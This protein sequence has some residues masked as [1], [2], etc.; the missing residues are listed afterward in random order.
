MSR[1]NA[2]RF[3]TATLLVSGLASCQK[4]LNENDGSQ[5][6]APTE[7]N[8]S[9]IQSSNLV[10][11]APSYLRN[12]TF[13]IY[14]EDP[15][16][17]GKLIAKAKLDESAKFA[18]NYIFPA[19][20]KSV[21]IR[22]TYVG[23]PDGITIPLE[24][25]QGFYDYSTKSSKS[26]SRS[27]SAPWTQSLNGKIYNYP[28][29]YNN[30][31]VPNYLT[32]PD[33]VDVALIADVNASLPERRPVPAFNPHYISDNVTTELKFNSSADVWVTFI[34]EGAGYR[35]TF[36]YYTYNINNKPTSP[37]DID[38]VTIVYPNVS[39][40]GSGGGLNAGDK[41]Y[42]GNFP[43][44]TGI[45]WV[46]IQNAW[47]NGAVNTNKTHF[48]S[49]ADL[50]PEST[51]D[52]RKHAVQLADFDR[53]IIYVG[54]EDLHRDGGSD[55]DF[56][57]A[58]FY[59]TALPFSAIDTDDIPLVTHTGMD[60]DGD[61]IPNS[62]DDYP[63]DPDKAFDNFTPFK[64]GFSSIAFE[65]Q[66]PNKGDYDFNDAV[67]D[68]NLNHITNGNN[69]MVAMEY[70]LKL[71]HMGAVFHNGFGIEW[72][73]DPSYIKSINGHNITDGLVTLN[74]NG[75]EAN[76]SKAVMIA[77]DDG[78]DNFNQELTILIEMDKP[79]SFSNLNLHGINPFLF[80]NELRGREIHLVDHTP[81]DLI[82]TSYYGNGHD[83]TDPSKGIYF[84][85]SDGSPWAVLIS[86]EYA[87]PVERVNISDAYTNFDDWVKSNGASGAD[88]Y[89]DK[90]GY[91]NAGMVY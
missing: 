7:F 69:Q 60:T 10:L 43:A 40:S 23:L 28:G 42:L 70:K 75:T 64:N 18:S 47:R 6:N 37:D 49:T 79:Y 20:L 57:D 58:I 84:R 16:T 39:A 13:E 91:R 19:T 55:D 15:E 14:T 87:A 80:S 59:V 56:N 68:L 2:V 54:M 8:Y 65:D 52:K 89:Q 1:K 21:F 27:G 32:T 51:H 88:W 72:P 81:T 26:Q 22:S 48:Y 86:S 71:R 74:P 3:L 41:V 50:N 31:G 76:Q 77:F 35:N 30:Q 46:V 11:T 9:T 36:G 90:P 34:H 82:N 61:G 25:G 85:H 73:F 66:W 17:G 38:E 78:Y 29:T 63:N 62:R 53:E 33:V 67:V 45:G 83:I 4:D 24:S 12:A 5:V 44:N